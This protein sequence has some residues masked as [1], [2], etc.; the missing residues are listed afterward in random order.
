MNR[1]IHTHTHT[2]K[3]KREREKNNIFLRK[4]E[5]EYNWLT[6]VRKRINSQLNILKWIGGGK[7]N[8]RHGKN[9]I[10]RKAL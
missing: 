7:Y 3:K 1:S 6:T 5:K 9:M 10:N 2:Q 8:Q 4:I